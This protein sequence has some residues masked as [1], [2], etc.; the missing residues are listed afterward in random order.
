[1]VAVVVLIS[2]W[3]ETRNNR[4]LLGDI[5]ALR[6]NLREHFTDLR[7]NEKLW[8]HTWS[9]IDNLE[10]IRGGVGTVI[11]RNVGLPSGT[12]SPEVRKV[13]LDTATPIVETAR[14]RLAAVVPNSDP[15]VTSNLI[16]ERPLP[17]LKHKAVSQTLLVEPCSRKRQRVNSSSEN[18]AQS[19]FR[20]NLVA[21]PGSSTAE[22]MV[23]DDSPMPLLRILGKTPVPPSTISVTPKIQKARR[24]QAPVVEAGI[25]ISRNSRPIDVPEEAHR[26]RISTIKNNTHA[27]VAPMTPSSFATPTP[28]S[29]ENR[30]FRPAPTSTSIRGFQE[31][32][33]IVNSKRP[34]RLPS[35]HKS[36]T[37]FSQFGD[38][39]DLTD[40]TEQERR[41]LLLQF[42]APTAHG[43]ATRAGAAED[44]TPADYLGTNPYKKSLNSRPSTG[45]F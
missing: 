15:S 31:L 20:P 36:A 37:S 34:M 28:G 3:S 11:N 25:H 7:L 29:L 17:V 14:M 6:E 12:A 24:S 16:P 42:K 10:R 22:P 30:R 4:L 5:G 13:P 39:I 40:D 41:N 9:Y 38:S 21:L 45:R 35:Q 44:S 43:N 1:M 33:N 8:K 19:V 23:L 32:T 26:S 2:Q 27:P 18:S